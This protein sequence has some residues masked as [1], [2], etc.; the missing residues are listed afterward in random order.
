MCEIWTV[1]VWPLVRLVVATAI[2]IRTIRALASA[3]TFWKTGRSS[4]CP[5]AEMDAAVMASAPLR[6]FARAIMASR[7]TR[8]ASAFQSV[9]TVPTATALHP[10]VVSVSQ[11]I[12]EKVSNACPFAAAVAPTDYARLQILAPAITATPSIRPPMVARPPVPTDVRTASVCHPMS[13]NATPVMRKVR[14]T[15]ARRRARTAKT[16]TASRP[17]PADATWAT[18][19]TNAASALQFVDNAVIMAAA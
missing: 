4:V 13:V 16:V 14:E 15:S 12:A 6:T 11:A 17:T 8:L 1:C 7:W 5:C 19:R 2:V 9:R 10:K 18:R 3:A